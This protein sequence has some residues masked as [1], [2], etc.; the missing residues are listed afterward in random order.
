[1]QSRFLIPLCCWAILSVD[2]VLAQES[3]KDVVATAVRQNGY[4]CSEPKNIEPDP[5]DT[6]PDERAWIV[7]CQNGSYRVKFMG[8]EGAQVEPL[9]E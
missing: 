3:P 2:L 7:R 9:F 8:D 1:M 6:S 5:E 4:Q